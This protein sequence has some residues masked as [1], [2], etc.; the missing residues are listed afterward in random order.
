MLKIT[1]EQACSVLGVPIQAKDSEIKASYR[2]LVKRYHPDNK[3]SGNAKAYELVQAAYECLCARPKETPKRI[4]S[5]RKVVG[6]AGDAKKTYGYQSR[7]ERERFEKHY[8]KQQAEKK[9]QFERKVEQFKIKEEEKKNE[10]IYVE[11]AA[12]IL[13]MMIQDGK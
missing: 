1:Y 3:E 6:G 10:A 5:S 11:R 2:R 4:K 8:V 9:E 7:K 12:E 13:R